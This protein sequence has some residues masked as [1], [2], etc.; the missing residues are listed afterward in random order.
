MAHHL[1]ELRNM[2]R[3]IGESSRV[4]SNLATPVE[5]NIHNTACFW[6]VYDFLRR[7]ILRAGYHLA[8]SYTEET[9]IIYIY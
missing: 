5:T 6:E 4:S 3:R 9:N 2:R 8:P 7:A 1:L